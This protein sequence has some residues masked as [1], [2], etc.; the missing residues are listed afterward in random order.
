MT[1]GPGCYVEDV[2]VPSGGAAA[3][4]KS[5]STSR[6]A[7]SRDS[8]IWRRALSFST[9]A[10][11]MASLSN[12]ISRFNCSRNA[13]SSIM[14]LTGLF[15]SSN[16]GSVNRGWVATFAKSNG[17]RMTHSRGYRSIRRG[18]DQSLGKQVLIRKQMTQ[19]AAKVPG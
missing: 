4:S 10:V 11:S 6:N 5:Q 15:V 2:P 8:A 14:V 19:V 12:W 7:S 3:A 17:R 1:Q 9:N 16:R 13:S 18:R